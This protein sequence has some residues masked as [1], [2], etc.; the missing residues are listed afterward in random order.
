MFIDSEFGKNYYF[1]ESYAFKQSLKNT[2]GITYLL[3]GNFT[4]PEADN[5]RWVKSKVAGG[6][7]LCPALLEAPKLGYDRLVLFG[8]DYCRRGDHR[9]WWETDDNILHHPKNNTL[10]PAKSDRYDHKQNGRVIIYNRRKP[11]D[12]QLLEPLTTSN[13]ETVYADNSYLRQMAHS[14]EILDKLRGDGMEIFKWGEWG[15]LDIP[16]IGL[17]KLE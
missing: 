14:N 8:C 1:P 15:L 11:E 3:Q 7:V 10:V 9:H 16:S 2:D 12:W 5:I 4:I 13:G 6:S 17:D